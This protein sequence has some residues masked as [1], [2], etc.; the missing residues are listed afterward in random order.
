MELKMT[1]S[2]KPWLKLYDDGVPHSLK[3]YP[4]KTLNQ[5]LRD[6][7]AKYPN[8]TAV[9]SSAHLPVAGRVGAELTYSELDKQSDA[10][11]VA[12]GKLGVKKGDRVGMMM[13]NC[14]QFVISFYAIL[15]AGASV[16]ALNPTFP[17]MKVRDHLKSAQVDTVILL[18]LFYNGFKTV[19][20]EAGIKNVIV[21]NVKDYLPKAA[22]FLFTIAKEKKGGHRIE[23]APEDHDFKTLIAQNMGQ[24]PNVEVSPK[25]IAI[26]QFTGGTTGTAKAAMATHQALVTNSIQGKAVLKGQDVKDTFIAA[27]PLFHVFGMISVLVLGTYMASPMYMV[28]NPRDMDEV[29]DVVDTYQPTLFMG[30]PAMYNAI[31]NH[32]KVAAGKIKLR[33]IRACISGSAPLPPVVKQ[34][35]EALTGG[36]VVEGFGMSETAVAVCCNPFFG[37]NRLGSIG[38]PMS[39]VVMKIVSL[40]DP[41]QEMPVGEKGEIVIDAPTLM[42]GYYNMPE[43][44]TNVLKVHPDGRTYLHTGDIGYMDKDGYFYIVDRKKD[45]VLIGGYNVYPANIEKV[46]MGHDAVQ[47]VGV[48]GIPHPD[49]PGQ[50]A[51][52]AF[53]VLKS[54]Q[55]C[56]E[57]ELIEYCKSHLARYEV[58]TRIEFVPEL[59]KTIVGKVLRRELR[60]MEKKSSAQPVKEMA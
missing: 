8:N 30:V 53:V 9:V 32:A 60:E 20:K 7:A 11:A 29:L 4:E 50:E 49:K 10:L 46:M 27:I 24:K 45:M 5:V 55:T 38:L 37:E 6:V 56:T 13:P 2:T 47:E 19:Q 26:L 58:P 42:V 57:K 17:P 1:Y 35:F 48:I 16:V 14:A 3:P 39:D 31:N 12:L 36:L 15:K 52:K 28:L 21:T 40:D 22:A 44:T 41:M 51:L 23:K 34:K 54:G 25:D 43:E 33:S 18:S 59:P